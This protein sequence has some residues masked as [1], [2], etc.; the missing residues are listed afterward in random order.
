MAATTFCPTTSTR[1]SEPRASWMNS[2]TR[3]LASSPRKASITASAA[4]AVSARITP[5]PCVPSSSFTTSGAPP[6]TL[7]KPLNV[8]GRVGEAG[9]R[10]ADALPGQQLQAAEF[11]ARAG[12]GL[13]LVGR[14]DAHHLELPDDRG[15][16]KGFRG[17]DAG[18]DGVEA[19]ERRALI[20]DRGLVRGDVHVAAQVID[21]V[22][23]VAAAV[24][25]PL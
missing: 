11:V 19:V 15:A 3:I 23:F 10:Q 9:H 18:N 4:L 1:M 2:C 16:V 14:E 22:H 8:L 12:D 13:R 5:M 24:R 20:D 25:R 7:I 17:A 6:T 21:H